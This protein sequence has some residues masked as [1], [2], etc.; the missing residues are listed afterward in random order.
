MHRLTRII[1]RK[2]DNNSFLIFLLLNLGRVFADGYMLKEATAN[3][4]LKYPC[5]IDLHTQKLSK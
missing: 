5:Y 4:S 3:N 1:A 2:I